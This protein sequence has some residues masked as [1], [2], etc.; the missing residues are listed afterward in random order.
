MGAG[1]PP[2]L[3]VLWRPAQARNYLDEISSCLMD[4]PLPRKKG[5]GNPRD[6]GP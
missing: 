5:N 1:L 3:D 4:P 2:D 6:T